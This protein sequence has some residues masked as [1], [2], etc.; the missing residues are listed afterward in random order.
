[1]TERS[2]AFIFFHLFTRRHRRVL[3]IYN[4]NISLF[5]RNRAG[6][7]HC[8]IVTKT[9]NIRSLTNLT[10]TNNRLAFGGYVGVFHA[11]VGHRLTTFGVHW[12]FT[13]PLRSLFTFTLFGGPTY[14]RRNNI[15]RAT[16]GILFVRATIGIGKNIG[17]I[18]FFYRFL[19][20]P[21]FPWLY[22]GLLLSM[23]YGG[24]N[25]Q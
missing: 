2:R 6:I 11:Q 14:P 3:C 9:N 23:G 20:R 7:R 4:G 10:R 24:R 8:L 15:N 25:T 1:M 5:F 16:N 19:F 13:R 21:T 12:G 18:N 22:R 17:V